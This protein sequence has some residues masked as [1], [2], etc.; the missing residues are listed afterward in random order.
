MKRNIYLIF[1]IVLASFLIQSCSITEPHYTS[2]KKLYGV[3]PGVKIKKVNE[4]LGVKPYDFYYNFS[5]GTVVYVYQYKHLYHKM[6]L[7]L[8]KPDVR[9]ENY[10]TTGG[11]DHYKKAG[12]IYMTFD[13]SSGSLIGYNSDAGRENSVN[14]MMHEN[15]LRE[16]DAD[17][18][19][20]ERLYIRNSRKRR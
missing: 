1:G 9:N 5:D 18:K 16:V 8:G 4:Q 19:K 6:K 2:I 3:E 14:V 11:K 20:Y 17:Y 10:L 12:N 15:T 7:V 13:Q